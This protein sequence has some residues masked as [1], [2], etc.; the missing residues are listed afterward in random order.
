MARPKP[1]YICQEC[2]Y[3]TSKWMGKCPDCAQWNSFEEEVSI[4]EIKNSSIAAAYT[5]TEKPMR[6]SEIRSDEKY[7]VVTGIDEFDRVMGNG[8]VEGSL[9]LIGG[10]PG[11]GKSTL[12]L[13]IAAQFSRVKN[14]GKILYVSGEESASQVADRMRRLNINEDNLY[15]LNESCFENILSYLKEWKPKL[16]VLDSIQTTVSRDIP[17]APGT[18]SQIREVTYQLMNH[19]KAMGITCFIIGHVTKEGN[20][21]GPKVL[22]HMVDT[23]VYFEGDQFNHY[24]LLRVIKNRYGNTNEVGIF[25]MRENG[26]LPVSNPSQYFL[27]NPAHNSY[28]RALTCI[29]EGTRSLFVEIQAL[30]VEN[31]FGNGRRTTQGIDS[32]RLAMLIAVIEKYFGLSLS[33]NDVYLNVVGGIKLNTRESD[34]AIIAAILSSL[35]QVPLDNSMVL[36][37]EVGLTGEIRSIP[38]AEMRLKEMAQLSYKKVITSKR[39]AKDNQGKY[40]LEIIGAQKAR[41]VENYLF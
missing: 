4:P 15:I 22:E 8:I 7:R 13:E 18:I 24:R 30:V 25:E 26:L 14:E 3:Q 6:L 17:S 19:A 11:I 12:L 32:N 34:L 35:R 39:I 41:D 28:G 9:S 40:P 37:G 33:V 1:K 31:K 29:I 21:A 2:G 10:E 5:K 20:I 23:V 38:L 27:E 16:L 36:L